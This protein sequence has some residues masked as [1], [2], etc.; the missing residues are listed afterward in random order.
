MHV[1]TEG[2]ATRV[3]VLATNA[4]LAEEIDVEAAKRSLEELQGRD[5]EESSVAR[6]RAE[7]RIALGG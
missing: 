5:D 1:S 2:G 7:A 4:Q 6:A 3:D